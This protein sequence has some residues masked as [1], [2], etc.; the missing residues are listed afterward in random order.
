MFKQ[1]G[2]ADPA[3]ESPYV[4]ADVMLAFSVELAVTYQYVPLEMT[5]TRSPATALLATSVI[6]SASAIA[7]PPPVAVTLCVPDM[8]LPLALVRMV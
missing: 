4:A 2:G 3:L 7:D 5:S 1:K 6:V 8:T